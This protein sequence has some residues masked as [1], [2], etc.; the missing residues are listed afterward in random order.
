MLELSSMRQDLPPYVRQQILWRVADV[1]QRARWKGLEYMLE[2]DLI[3]LRLDAEIALATGCPH[4]ADAVLLMIENLKERIRELPER[5]PPDAG[6]F[7][8]GH[9]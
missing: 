8:Y 1:E 3:A 6:A 4:Q 7:T 9:F 5:E 2:F